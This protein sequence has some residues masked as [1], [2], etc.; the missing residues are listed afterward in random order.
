MDGFFL[1][2]FLAV[3]IVA[4]VVI[5]FVCYRLACA[6]QLLTRDDQSMLPRNTTPV[7]MPAHASRQ[8]RTPQLPHNITDSPLVTRGSEVFTIYTF[9]QQSTPEQERARR[10]T[11]PPKYSMLSDVPPKYEDLFPLP[12]CTPCKV[13]NCLSPASLH[14]LQH[15][16][17]A[18]PSYASYTTKPPALTSPSD[19]SCPVPTTSNTP[20]TCSADTSI[21]IPS[22]N[23]DNVITPDDSTSSPDSSHPAYTTDTISH[24]PTTSQTDTTGPLPSTSSTTSPANTYTSSGT[25]TSLS[26]YPPPVIRVEPADDLPPHSTILVPEDSD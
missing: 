24:T 6:R 9:S 20:T 1:S 14:H 15:S 26:L 3:C 10:I 11:P 8:Q 5:R 4:A 2:M 21:P 7:I 13:D 17:S 22:T 18:P 16:S 25:Q 19:S 12:N 23:P